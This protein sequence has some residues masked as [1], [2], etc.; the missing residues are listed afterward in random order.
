MTHFSLHPLDTVTFLQQQLASRDATIAALTEQLSL[1]ASSTG[2]SMGAMAER[3]TLVRSIAEKTCELEEE[4]A[5]LGKAR[6][7]LQAAQTQLL[8]TQKLEAIG[9]LAAGIA[10]EINTPA[11]FATD[12]TTFLRKSFSKMSELAREYRQLLADLA[13]GEAPTSERL[14]SE[15]SRLGKCRLDFLLEETPVAIDAALEGLS[16]IASIVRAMKEFSHPSSGQKSA[17]DL[18]ELVRTTVTVAR[19]EWKYVADV[20][21]DFDD[22]VPP[23]PCFRDELSQVVLNLLVNASHAID[24]ATSGGA[25]GKGIITISLHQVDDYVELLIRDTGTGIPEAIRHRIF[26]PFFTTKPVGK[27]T[28]QGL[29]IA[30]SVVVDKH[31]GSIEVDSTVGQGTT[32]RICLPLRDPDALA[33]QPPEAGR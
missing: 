9:S 1:I 2:T 8:H 32:F 25:T 18:R 10:H 31:R 17:I 7:N 15:Q 3:A 4:R 28:G 24:A 12:N 13:R 5:E 27:G 29:A 21:T 26:E 33:M 11:Q 22:A 14:Q 20:E 6:Q 19:N 23:V 16:R 30:Y